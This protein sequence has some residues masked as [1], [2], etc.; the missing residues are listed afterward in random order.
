MR[1][2]PSRRSLSLSA[3]LVVVLL[4]AGCAGPKAHDAAKDHAHNL[5]DIGRQWKQG[6]ELVAS[7]E[8]TRA[9]GE[10]LMAEGQKQIAAG[11]SQINRG[12]VLMSESETAF[13]QASS[14]ASK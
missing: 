11:D 7:G 10:A 1:N 8:K 5:Q 12:K 9:K 2:I 3:S 14:Q 13:R 6:S 4:A